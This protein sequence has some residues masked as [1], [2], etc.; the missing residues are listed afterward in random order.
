MPCKNC[1]EYVNFFSLVQGM[2][3]GIHMLLF[4]TNAREVGT[5]REGKLHHLRRT[6]QGLDFLCIGAPHLQAGVEVKLYLMKSNTF[7]QKQVK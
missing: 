3:W 6:Y 4:G 5:K 7:K 1:L 2:S